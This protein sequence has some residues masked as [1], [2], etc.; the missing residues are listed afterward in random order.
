MADYKFVK[1]A[2]FYREFLNDY[3]LRFPDEKD[4]SYSEQMDGIMGRAVGWAR[5]IS[6]HLQQLGAGA[7]EIIYN[8]QP[9]QAAWAKENGVNASGKDIV[10]EQ[11]KR[12]K[13][14]VVMF[15]DSINFNGQWISMLRSAVPSIK[16][17]I[18]WCCSPLPEELL[19]QYS[20]FDFSIV[21]SPK[22]T[23]DFTRAGL[24][25]YQI[26]HAFEASLA[27]LVKTDNGFESTDFLFTGS[28]FPGTGF[29]N[30]R[31]RILKELTEAGID[32]SIYGNIPVA[33]PHTLMMRKASYIIARM[34]KSAGL[35]HLAENLPGI[36]KSLY[37]E[38]MPENTD[39]SIL[40]LSKPALFGIDMLKA[41]YRAKAVFNSHG[42]AA[43]GYAANIR[44]FEVTGVGSCLV[45]DYKN[46]IHELFEPDSEIVVYNSA[47][48]CIEKV[49]W[50]LENPGQRQ[51]IAEAGQK[52]TL[53]SHTLEQRTA[54]ID[55]I[56]REELS[57]I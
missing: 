20:T 27:E 10:L 3:Y 47:E 45:T 23:E 53:K 35:K 30:E 46:N 17:V 4:K 12:L 13:P 2:S 56:I 50:L 33:A 24:R 1:V 51:A 25:T 31:L 54:V 21:C 5:F 32:I 38:S 22:F 14:E 18:G 57:R 49:K 11:L 34:M 55:G 9:L 37:L 41:L 42:E 6:E 19:G 8:A 28:I 43:G 48:E 40:R 44:L 29:H 26:Y 7:H 16:L 36:S 39:K 52:R 15:Q